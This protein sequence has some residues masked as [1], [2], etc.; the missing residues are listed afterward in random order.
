MLVLAFRS[1]SSISAY[2]VALRLDKKYKIEQRFSDH[3]VL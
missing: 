2:Y 3:I 1:F